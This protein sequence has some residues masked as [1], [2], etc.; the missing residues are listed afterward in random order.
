[1]RVCVHKTHAFT[2]IFPLFFCLH[3]KKDQTDVG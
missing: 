2:A 1:M 3:L